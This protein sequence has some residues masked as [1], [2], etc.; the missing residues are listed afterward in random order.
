MVDDHRRRA[1][2]P[3]HAHRAQRRPAWVIGRVGSVLGEAGINIADMHLGQ[4]R[5]AWPLMVL[6]TDRTLP[7]AVQESPAI[8]GITSVHAIDLG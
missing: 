4:S 7:V 8:E 1:A 5:T 3:A 2:E 6:A